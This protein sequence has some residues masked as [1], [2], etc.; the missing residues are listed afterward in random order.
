MPETTK[1][2]LTKFGVVLGIFV[3]LTAILTVLIYA[4][5]FSW[6][7]GLRANA[8]K[9]LCQAENNEIVLG[10][11]VEITSAFT[12][13]MACF[14]INRSDQ[15]AIIMRIPTICGPV[16]AV[17]RYQTGAEKG[18]FVDYGVETGRA[19]IV[20]DKKVNVTGIKYWEEKIPLILNEV[21]D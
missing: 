3:V 2:F 17:F 1:K 12:T 16:P 4:A 14:K 9:V 15:Y 11:Q 21:A 7:M 6:N 8:Q 18:E 10:E 5:N 13:S 20:L 19:N